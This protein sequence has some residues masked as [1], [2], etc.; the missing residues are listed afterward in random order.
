MAEHRLGGLEVHALRHQ[1]GG[2][3][4]PQVV[5]PEALVAGLPGRLVLDKLP[6][7]CGDGRRVPDPALGIAQ[8]PI[9]RETAR[10][11]DLPAEAED[12]RRVIAPLSSAMSRVE[13]VHVFGKGTGI[14]APQVGIRRAAALVRTPAGRTITHIDPVVIE[15]TRGDEQYEGCLSFL[16]VRGVV[17][18]ALTLHV[19][20]LNGI[21]YTDRMAPGRG[22]I[23]VSE[24]RQGGENWTY[25]VSSPAML[26]R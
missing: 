13:E 14:A 5:E 19:D 17:N 11:F 7:A 1:A 9:L 15:E 25:Q 8:E 3:G 22:P 21:L 23:P 18:R 24:Y 10:P 4:P 6:E 20:H 26:P 12:A 2:V 16:D